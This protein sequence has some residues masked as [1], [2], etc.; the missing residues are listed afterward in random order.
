MTTKLTMAD[1][2]EAFHKNLRGGGGQ[3]TNFLRLNAGETYLRL[4]PSFD[5]EDP[6]PYR[7][8]RKH[9]FKTDR[10]YNAVDYGYLLENTALA[11]LAVEQDRIS[12]SDLE[13]ALKYGDPFTKLAERHR[14]ME[15]DVPRGAWPQT[16]YL[17]NAVNRD[18]DGE[19]GVLDLSK[20]VVNMV[21]GLLKTFDDLFD[22]E[23]GR[24]ILIQGNGKDKLQRRYEGVSPAKDTSP[25]GFEYKLINL[26]E[27]IV[28][29]VMPYEEKVQ[30]MFDK[31]GNDAA[32]VGLS[33]D[34]FSG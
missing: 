4:L 29:G 25:V 7:V 17:F 14:A 24:D 18:N 30:A 22:P 26:D 32:Q 34:D 21:A 28:R 9:S 23:N 31:Y 10:F 5:P 2:N 3:G 16:R 20:T 33:E 27:V 1:V 19:V 6:T 8:L 15:I 13:L 11:E 12:N